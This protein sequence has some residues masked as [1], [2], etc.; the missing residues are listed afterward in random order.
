MSEVQAI[1]GAFQF[2]PLH[3]RQH[4]RPRFSTANSL[5]QFTP[6]HERQ[7]MCGLTPLER[8]SFQ[9]TPLHERQLGSG[10]LLLV[11]GTFQFT[12]L[13]ERQLSCRGSYR[14]HPYFNSRLYMRGNA[15]YDSDGNN[16]S[17]FNSRL[18]M[19][20]NHVSFVVN[21][22]FGISIHAST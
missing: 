4:M 6:L 18:Y 22:I 8:Y 7:L 10:S 1:S 17:Y 20:G 3:E 13:H 2:T 15:F 12:P 9:F 5:F 19:R 21:T 11:L 16:M 14:S